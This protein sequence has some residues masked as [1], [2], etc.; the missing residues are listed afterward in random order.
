MRSIRAIFR[1]DLR[2][3][4]ASIVSI[5]ILLGLCVVPCL[6]AWFNIFSN[7]DPYGPDATSRIP[8]AVVSED[9]GGSLLGL[10]MNIGDKILEALE[11]NDTIGWVFPESKDE[12]M[13]LLEKSD[14]YAVLVVS[15][16]FTQDVFDSL[17]GGSVNPKL[18]YYENDKKNAIAPKITGKAKTAVQQQVNTTFIETITGYLAD[19]A[20]FLSSMGVDGPTLIAKLQS[21]SQ[22]IRGQLGTAATALDALSGLNNTA[23]T[24][25]TCAYQF[26]GDAADAATS[27]GALLGDANT[28]LSGTGSL[29]DKTNAAARDALEAVSTL[30]GD[31]QTHLNKASQSLDD[32][33]TY[34]REKLTSQIQ[35]VAALS[36]QCRAM[37]QQ[38]QTLGA[39]QAAQALE[40]LAGQLDGVRRALE[41]VQSVADAKLD[42]AAALLTTASQVTAQAQEAVGSLSEL[43]SQETTQQV[44]QK[45]QG[46]QQTLDGA[47]QLL[48]GTD[49]VSV[50]I[51]QAIT[52]FTAQLSSLETGLLQA[53]SGLGLSLIHI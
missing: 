11:A 7:W 42:E 47:A 15:D 3:V 45:L 27:A 12:A 10:E 37:S 22:S 21:A 20:H 50:S 48:A 23:Q 53:R 26:T 44:Q 17:S 8:V 36:Q 46:L 2:R 6:Y 14:C 40:A 28:V 34:T 49:S 29:I 43:V 25:L 24:I 16:D 18:H 32:F 51:R 39:T 1:G 41:T 30:L 33:H 13:T 5:V 4:T 52:D 31:I 19:F 38:L 9:K 35:S